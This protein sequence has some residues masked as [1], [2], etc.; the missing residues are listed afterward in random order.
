MC[1]SLAVWVRSSDDV[2]SAV[3]LS[4]IGGA[5]RCRSVVDKCVC[6]IDRP[7][8]WLVIAG[9]GGVSL[10]RRWLFGVVLSSGM[11]VLI[12][13]AAVQTLL[14]VCVCVICSPIVYVCS[15]FAD[16]KCVY[17]CYVFVDRACVCARAHG[18]PV[19]Q[20]E[21]VRVYRVCGCELIIE[22]CWTVRVA[23][24]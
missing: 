7:L 11:C 15:I 8:W 24:G 19:D 12:V 23:S 5:Y 18:C 13:C 4:V 3:Q 17:V 10:V 9:E 6:V 21:Q 1:V 22:G 16:R 2:C 14:G 20:L